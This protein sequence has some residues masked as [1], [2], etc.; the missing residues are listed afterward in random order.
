M[1]W[2]DRYYQRTRSPFAELLRYFFAGLFRLESAADEDSYKAW[3]IQILALLITASWY[4]PVNLHRRYVELHASLIRAQYLQAYSSDCLNAVVLMTLIVALLTVVEWTELF[5]SRQDH[6]VLTP[7]PITRLQFFAAKAAA[8]MLFVTLVIGSMAMIA[9]VSLPGIASGVLETRPVAWRMIAFFLASLGTCY[10]TFWGL[11]AVQGCFMAILPVR[12]FERASLALQLTLLVALL[13]ALPLF[14]YFPAGRLI[15]AQ[16]T[17]LAWLP[18]AWYWGWAE[19]LLGGP[20]SSNLAHRAEWG[21]A[22][23]LATASLTYLISYLQYTRYA[24]ESA[25]RG[26]AKVIDLAAAVARLF[27][28]PQ[29]RGT[30]EFTLRTLARCRRQKLVFMLVFGIGVALVVESST[31][32]ALH[33]RRTAVAIESAIIAAPLTLSFFAMLG[34]RRAFRLP[35]ELRANWLF[36]FCED[37]ATRDAQLNAVLKCFLLLGAL[38]LLGICAPLEFIQFGPRAIFILAAQSALMYTM[39]SYLLWD[40]R[41]IPFTVAQNPGRR[42]FIQSVVVHIVELAAFSFTASEWIL[43]GLRQP[44]WFAVLA[45]LMLGTLLVLSNLRKSNGHTPLEFAERVPEAVEALHLV[46]D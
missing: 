26:R 13:C 23:A 1:N 42:H 12:W 39:A 32:M 18:P 4:I 30:C 17:W 9:G 31:Y 19:K 40:W 27:P 29:S 6:L 20:D 35:E 38:P 45:A 43:A 11:L 24:L 46:A 34:L 14:P 7:L 44:V 33:P 36:Q 25:G 3:M 41:A 2:V 8:L 21:L 28:L 37:P 16:S 5:P 10:F 22:A 15:A